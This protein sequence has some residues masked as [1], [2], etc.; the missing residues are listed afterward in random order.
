MKKCFSVFCYIV[1]LLCAIPNKSMSESGTNRRLSSYDLQVKELLSKMTL[2]EKIGQMTQAE[3]GGLKDITDIEKYY[4]GSILSGGSSDPENGNS[5]Q[6]WTDLYDNY[7]KH[8]LKTRLGIPL[9]YGI[10]AVHG[11][12]NVFGAVIFPHNIG[13]GC[14]RDPKLVE[15]IARITAIEVRATGI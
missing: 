2:E 9:L 6:A 5:L 3:H 12:N 14:T 4:L 15:Q 13:L 1:I 8:T 7:Q 11:H 10:D